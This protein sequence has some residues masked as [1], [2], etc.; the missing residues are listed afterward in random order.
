MVPLPPQ[1]DGNGPVS[2]PST[3]QPPLT[4]PRSNPSPGHPQ[5]EAPRLAPSWL[6]D[7][8]TACSEQVRHMLINSRRRSTRKTYRYKWTRFSQWYAQT[9]ASPPHLAP[10]HTLLDYLLSLKHSGLALS[11]IKV[12]A[13]AIAAFH[14]SEQ[15]TSFLADPLTKLFFKGLQNTFPPVWPPVP[16]W[17]LNHVLKSL[18]KPPFEPIATCSLSHLSMKVAFLVAITSSRRVS[19]LAALMADPPYTVFLQNR[20]ILRPHPKFLPKVPSPFHVNEPIHLPAF[21]PKPHTEPIQTV[22]HTLDVR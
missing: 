6:Q 16:I 15:G 4:K 11:T 18:T 2:L 9:H 17:D 3:S 19:E 21:F 20:V 12:H 22:W 1:D 10:V 14:R 13:A 7:A 8:E 5:A